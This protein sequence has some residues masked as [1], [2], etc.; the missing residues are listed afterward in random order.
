[1]SSYSF[2]HRDASG[3]LT[4]I[5]K[6]DAHRER[7]IRPSDG[8]LARLV[9]QVADEDSSLPDAKD[10][11]RSGKIRLQI[12]PI[13]DLVHWTYEPIFKEGTEERI[14]TA[15]ATVALALRW[16]PSCILLVIMV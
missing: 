14:Y 11:T 9:V 5:E 1:M 16:I 4:L 12:S 13:L 7:Y 10:W 8:R 6:Q 15:E 2:R 3:R